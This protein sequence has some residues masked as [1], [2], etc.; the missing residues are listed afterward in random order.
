LRHIR[1][2]RVV[3]V[4]EGLGHQSLDCTLRVSMLM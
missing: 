4:D 2:T 1:E 3:V